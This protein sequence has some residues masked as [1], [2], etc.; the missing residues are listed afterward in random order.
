MLNL[1]SSRLGDPVSRT[2]RGH[3][4]GSRLAPLWRGL[5]TPAC[6]AEASRA[7]PRHFRAPRVRQR[8]DGCSA[9][10]GFPAASDDRARRLPGATSRS[11]A[12]TWGRVRGRSSRPPIA[13][14]IG[15]ARKAVT[16]ALPPRCGDFL[17]SPQLG[18]GA[19]DGASLAARRGGGKRR[20]R[21]L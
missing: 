8:P 13:C 11:G 16:P 3:L 18:G 1:S 5:F 10:A 7:R 20:R 6:F 9:T 4:R 19:E 21:Y 2:L 17:F 15:V 14:A 12:H